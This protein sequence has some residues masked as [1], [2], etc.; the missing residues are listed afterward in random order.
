MYLQSEYLHFFSFPAF[1][2]DSK[3]FDFDL[4]FEN[5]AS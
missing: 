2:K 5:Q 3:Y 4:D 1:V